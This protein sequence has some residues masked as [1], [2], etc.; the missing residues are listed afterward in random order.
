MKGAKMKEKKVKSIM[1]AQVHDELVFDCPK[2]EI[3]E[4]RKIYEYK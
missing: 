1:I 4:I 2:E 3:D